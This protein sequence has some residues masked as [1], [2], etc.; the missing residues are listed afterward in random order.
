M[1]AIL[2]IVACCAVIPLAM[3]AAAFVKSRGNRR[4]DSSPHK[5]MDS[6]EQALPRNQHEND[7]R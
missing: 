2:A 7:G 6:R 5:P 3:V 4:I 1:Y